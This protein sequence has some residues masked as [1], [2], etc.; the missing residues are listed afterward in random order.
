MTR[1]VLL[2]PPG[3]GK[4]TQAAVLSRELG[5]P[6]VSTGAIFRSQ[7]EQRTPMGVELQAIVSSGG[8]VPDEIT[9]AV[10]TARLG[11]PDVQDGF[12][13][14]G[15]PRTEVQVDD[16]EAVLRSGPGPLTRVFLLHAPE[17]VLISRLVRR[18][19]EQ[20]RDDDA[21]AVVRARLRTH[22]DTIAPIVDRYEQ[23]HLLTRVDADRPPEEVSADLLD[24][25]R[26]GVSG[27]MLA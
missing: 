14:D 10:V 25:V 11:E 20:H 21:P 16:L 18:G 2:G 1:I 22:A 3:A 9:T 5:I 8:L 24:V 19:A 26:A 6:A 7:I 13:L 15:Y 12:V 4:G 17:D 27:G 23:R